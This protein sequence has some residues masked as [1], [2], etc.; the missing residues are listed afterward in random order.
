MVGT[1][2]AFDWNRF[3]KHLEQPLILAGGL[4]PANVADA[5]AT[6]QPWAIDVSS[7]VESS[8]GIKDE[9][10]IQEFMKEVSNVR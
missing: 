1:G 9:T 2:E 8:R 4:T 3:P 6:V 10:L 7:G 5:I